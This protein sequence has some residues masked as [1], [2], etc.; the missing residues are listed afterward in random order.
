ML[1]FNLRDETSTEKGHIL[2]VFD[3]LQT[4]RKLLTMKLFKNSRAFFTQTEVSDFEVVIVGAG[5]SK[6]VFAEEFAYYTDKSI[7]IVDKRNHLAGNCDDSIDEN[8]IRI[9]KYGAHL[10]HTN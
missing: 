10:F 9:N 7:L 2:H 6:S 8:C 1:I 3:Q 4:Q 5:L